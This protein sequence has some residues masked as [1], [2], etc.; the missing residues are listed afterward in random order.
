M[1]F[2]HAKFLLWFAYNCMLSIEK[3]HFTYIKTD[4]FFSH[5]FEN[6]PKIGLKIRMPP[7]M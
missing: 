3:F 5:E 7:D 6:L 2:F 4:L 1:G